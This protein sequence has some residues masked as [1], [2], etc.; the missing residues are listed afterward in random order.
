MAIQPIDVQTLFAK[1]NQVGKEQAA[2]KD[3][4]AMH[5]AAQNTEA[6]K[7]GDQKSHTVNKPEDLAEGP[8]KINEEAPEKQ[9]S[10]E[11]QE[12]EEEKQAA[13]E[14]NEENEIFQDPDLGKHIDISG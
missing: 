3:I 10:E 8:R 1:L 5:Q 9:Q 12:N 11:Q 6:I 13:G 14:K 2:M 7:E 4:S